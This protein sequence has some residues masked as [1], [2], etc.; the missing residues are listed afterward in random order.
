MSPRRALARLALA[1]PLC[2]AGAAVAQQGEPSPTPPPGEGSVNAAAAPDEAGQKKS[3]VEEITVTGSRVR[4]KDLTTPA[5]VTVISREQIVTSGKATIAEFLQSLPEQGNAANTSMNNGGDGATRVSLRGLGAART[6]VLVNGRRFVPGGTGADIAVDLNSIPSSVVDRVEVLKDGA[7]AVYGSDAIGGVVNIITRRNWSGTEASAYAGSSSRRDGQLY[8]LSFTTGQSGDTGSILFFGS[9]AQQMKSMAG[10]RAF[11]K[12]PVFY[13]AGA[14]VYS[15]GSGTIPAGRFVLPDSE[16]GV[17]IPNPTNDPRLALYNNLMSTYGTSGSFI[18]DPSAPLGWRPYSAGLPEID[19]T[20]D[21]Y[22][23]QPE[24]YLVTPQ[25]RLSLYATGDTHMGSVGRAFFEASYMNRQSGQDLASE[26]LATDIEGVVVSAANQY[27]PFGRDIAAFR[28]RL[29]EFSRRTFRQDIDTLRTVG[30]F[31]GSLPDA[32]GPLAGW[33]WDL[34]LNYGRTQGTSVKAGNL[35]LPNLQAALGPSQG[36]VCYQNHD[37][38][39]NTYANPI[40]GCV[41]LNLFGGAGSITPDQTAPLTY[42]GTRRGTNQLASLQVNTS[43]DLFRLASDRPVG[44]AVGYEFRR[45]SGEFLQDP[46]T[47]AGETTGNKA[48][49]TGG[50]FEVNEVY[51]ELTIPLVTGKAFADDLELSAAARWFKYSNFGSDNTY[52]VG[53]RYRP[54]R[55]VTFRGTYSTAFRAP[56]IPDL[57]TGLG[58]NFAPLSDPC[59]GPPDGPPLTPEVA[60]RCGAAANNG[61]DQSQLRSTVGGNAALK[62]ETA[63]IVTVGVVLEP[64]FAKGLS[65]TV[66]YY[67][68]RIEE[69]ISPVGEP[70]ILSGCYGG[71]APEFCGFITRDP[72][73]HFITN[74]QNVT[75]NVGTEKMS[76][77]DVA[78]RYALPTGIGR[79]TGSVDATFLFRYDVVLG[80]GQVM[81]GRGTYDLASR[82]SGVGG[83]Y[84]DLKLNVGVIWAL[85][86]FGAG[87]STRFIGSY[88]ECG[89]S[90]GDFSGTGLCYEDS[91]Y[92]RKVSS[93]STYDAFVSYALTSS[94]G[95]TSVGLGVNNLTDAKPPAIYNAFTASADPT[96]YD[97]M[98]RY[99]YV[100][101]THKY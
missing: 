12:V 65:L 50:S 96:A 21:S 93:Y 70:V 15:G 51:G 45:M 28:R 89:D 25:Q 59:R 99:L 40:A 101:L 6:L 18:R 66:D 84:P 81:K 91:R 71:S 32:A 42:T 14:G 79:F 23:F 67:D 46:V 29:V 78:A 5:P 16:V 11:S 36:G 94:V 73:F 47:A 92:S 19:G 55:D 61:D 1:I 76:G 97:F 10:D 63:K 60:A 64:R 7:S 82:N 56:S 88:K 2:L 69:T 83:V 58:D 30:G 44:L 75:Q 39:T 68:L 72:V 13:D 49:N 27:N 90:A 3:V 8:D 52:K 20:G 9:Y 33:F 98:G 57:Y 74:I 53:G 41:P 80:N 85:R 48:L 37:A 31:D 34:S 87:L 100:R 62:P 86:G 4:R 24:N 54:L 43:G 35:R 95:K 77:L 26:P 38:A 17:L 22:N